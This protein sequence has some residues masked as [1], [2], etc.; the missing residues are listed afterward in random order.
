[1]LLKC[2][3]LLKFYFLKISKRFYFL[4]LLKVF[5]TYL[6]KINLQDF[7][8]SSMSQTLINLTNLGVK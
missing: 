5:Y 8:L 2:V 1:M 7:Q 6:N 3:I 4:F